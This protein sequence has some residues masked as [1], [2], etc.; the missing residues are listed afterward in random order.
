MM[1]VMDNVE[2][3][4]RFSGEKFVRRVGAWKGTHIEDWTG[5]NMPS[6]SPKENCLDVDIDI[7]VVG[8]WSKES[9]NTLR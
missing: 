5:K 6:C 3:L 2:R 9:W 4:V 7:V 8:W 1:T